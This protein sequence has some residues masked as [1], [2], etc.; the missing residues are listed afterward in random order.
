LSVNIFR[1][2]GERVRRT[3]I[4]VR[5]KPPI[6]WLTARQA[7]PPVP[8]RRE[9]RDPKEAG[10]LNQQGAHFFVAATAAASGDG[11]RGGEKML[12]VRV[13]ETRV[14]RPRGKSAHTGGGNEF[15]TKTRTGL[16]RIGFIEASTVG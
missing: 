4:E 15:S 6:R 8:E 7:K 3:R 9:R 1:C 10:E 16:D 11:S 14:P 13:R 5:R 2:T 12:R